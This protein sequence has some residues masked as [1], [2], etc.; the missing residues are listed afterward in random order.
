MNV[1]V[2]ERP[3][4]RQDVKLTTVDCDIHPGMV[5]GAE[6]APFLPQRWRDHMKTYGALL[7]GGLSE[8]PVT[9]FRMAPDTARADAFPPNG[10]PPGSDLAFMRELHLDAN[11]IQ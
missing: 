9:H 6:L 1:N 4:A 3:D 10:G 11:G 5:S 8:S 7:R 2:L